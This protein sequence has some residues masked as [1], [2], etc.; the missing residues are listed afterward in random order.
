MWDHTLLSIA[1]GTHGSQFDGTLGR[2]APSGSG[3]V[4]LLEEFFKI[5]HMSFPWDPLVMKLTQKGQKRN[6][7]RK[8]PCK[9]INF[10]GKG[11]PM[12]KKLTNLLYRTGSCVSHTPSQHPQAQIVEYIQ[13]SGLLPRTLAGS[14]ATKQP[15]YAGTRLEPPSL[16]AR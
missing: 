13:A 7:L 6:M 14:P 12:M 1:L 15:K 2:D 10:N 16:W 3:G 11:G 4:D 8:I 9:T 5:F